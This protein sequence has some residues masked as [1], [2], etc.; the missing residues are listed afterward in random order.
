MGGRGSKSGGTSGTSLG[1]GGAVLGTVPPPVP[2]ANPAPTSIDDQAPDPTNTP[3]TP[4]AVDVLA[5]MSDDQ[6]AALARQ[7]RTVQM[8]NH[9][10]D[11]R[12][13]TQQFV[14]AAG[15]NGKPDVLDTAAFNQYL[16][17]NGI[18]PSNILSRTSGGADYYVNGTHLQLT[19][20]QTGDILKYSDLNYIGGKHGGMV[21]GAGAYFDMDGGSRSTGY[22][23]SA[24]GKPITLHAVLKKD[25]K[26][27][28][29]STLRRNAVSFQRTHP[30]FA[31]TV[32][33]CTSSNQSIYA[34]AMG[35][36]V[37]RFGSYHTVIDRSAL[38]FDSSNY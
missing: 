14:F 25:A 32:G 24:H 34:L 21:H 17:Q 4:S 27:I 18:S 5:N 26:V 35:Y 8:P 28:D 36:Q 6:L 15:V 23:N 2:P 19:P 11:R 22:G 30:K 3:V 12:D 10:N 7:A 16:Q 9:L 33:S 38:V 37:V 13:Q 31:A 1:G 29:E 20:T